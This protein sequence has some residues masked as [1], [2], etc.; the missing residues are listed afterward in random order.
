MWHRDVK[1]A[2]TVRKMALIDPLKA[3]LLQTFNLWKMQ[4]VVKFNTVKYNKTKY[5]CMSEERKIAEDGKRKDG[6]CDVYVYL[7]VV[8]WQRWRYEEVK[9]RDLRK[10]RDI[11]YRGKQGPRIWT[12]T[13]GQLGFIERFRWRS[14][15]IGILGVPWCPSRIWYWHCCGSSSIPGPGTSTCHGTAKKKKKI[16]ILERSLVE[17]LSPVPNYIR[18]RPTQ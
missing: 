8:F 7:F 12:S 13:K 16:R 1:W 2:N 4:L 11:N 6:L 10:V 3:R 15:K 17:F 9:G 14:N 18:H 5:A